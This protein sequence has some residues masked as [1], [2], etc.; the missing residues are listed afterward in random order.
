MDGQHLDS[1]HH[2]SLSHSTQSSSSAIDLTVTITGL[3]GTSA[4]LSPS[5]SPTLHPSVDGGRSVARRRA[6]WAKLDAGQDPLCPNLSV[7]MEAGPSRISPR[8]FTADEDPV[9][10]PDNRF[11]ANALAYNGSLIYNEL[12]YTAAQ[13]DPSSASLI[14]TLESDLD[15]SKDRDDVHLTGTNSQLTLSAQEVLQA[16]PGGG[17]CITVPHLPLSNER[18]KSHS[19]FTIGWYIRL[20]SQGLYLPF[21][22]GLSVSSLGV[23]STD[24][25]IIISDQEGD[26]PNS[27]IQSFDNIYYAVLQVVVVTSADGWS[28][29]MYSIIDT[30]FF[31]SCFYF[32]VCILVLNIWLI[33]LF[34]AVIM[35]SF[36]AIHTDTQKSAFGVAPLGL[37]VEEQE[38]G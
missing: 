6:S 36:S 23:S 5:L 20:H 31:V 34:V 19:V 8:P 9:Y 18:A 26:N 16:P 25:D 12:P 37:V 10:F 2:S 30:K 3:A 1:Q 29:I 15:S 27:G 7:T 14:S 33:N 32:I 13:A 38:E 22:A 11:F 24:D 4:P 17:R 21:G 28:P 35:N